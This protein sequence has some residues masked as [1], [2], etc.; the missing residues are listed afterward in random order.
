VTDERPPLLERHT[1]VR[2]LHAWLDEAA[3][4]RGRLVLVS[5]EAGIGKTALLSS[6][7][8]E[9]V[10][11]EVLWG[12][13][14]RLFTPRALGPFVDIAEQVDGALGQLVARGAA[15]HQF[16]A[17]LSDELRARTP[18]VLVIEDVHWA[19]EAT[20]DVI[21]L[22]SRR[23]DQ[24]PALLV[25]SF[26]DDELSVA[27]PLQMV[28]GELAGR[29]RVERI[30]VP[31]LSRDAVR[32][33]AQPFGADDERVFER[34]AGN[35]F[36]VT[37]V[38]AT[39]DARLPA[40]VRDAVLARAAH[41]PGAS[42]RLL[43]CAAAVPSKV[44]IWLLEAIA[45]GDL[46][47]L[48]TCLASGMLRAEG[49]HVAFRHELARLAI[50]E[51]TAP[52]RRV[53]LHRAILKTL[54]AQ[55]EQLRDVARLAHHGEAAGDGEAVLEF[56]PQAARRAA[57]LGSHREAAEQYARALRYAEGLPLEA[58]AD[59]YERRGYECH[60]TDQLA[61][62]LVAAREALDR[63][64]ALGQRIRE[65]DTLVFIS[66]LLWFLGRSEESQQAGSA[67]LAMLGELPDSPEL[68]TAY[69]NMARISLLAHHMG[70]AVEWGTKAIPLAERFEATGILASALN[71]IGV[72]ELA[73]GEVDNGRAKLQRSLE[74]ARAA[75]LEEHVARALVNLGGAMLDIRNYEV[76]ARYIAE[77]LEYTADREL[78]SFRNFLLSIQ[79]HWQLEQGLWDEALDTAELALRQATSR[80]IS[81]IRVPSLRVIGLI[82]ARRGDPRAREALDEALEL[83]VPEELQQIAPVAAACAE[84]A[85]LADDPEAVARITD[86]AFALTRERGD[87]RRGGDL[88]YWR[89][90]AGIEDEP[91]PWITQPYR[92]QIEGDWR[93]AAQDWLRLGCPYEA[94]LA[95][96]EGD[97]EESLRAALAE[98]QRLGAVATARDVTR[99]LRERG[100]RRIGRGPRASTRSNPAGLTARELDVVALLHLQNSEIAARL[101]IS[102]KTVDHHVSAILRKLGVSTRQKAMV[103]AR[104][105]GIQP[106]S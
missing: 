91:G 42:R 60:L 15:P 29:P 54:R 66:R 99:R 37:E 53:A 57:D 106:R 50:D 31:A 21:T 79:A 65:G 11:A 81:L 69:A 80:S 77:G 39:G 67:A 92:R 17:A 90:K 2:A 47:A 71:T 87:P 93:G 88:A 43:E 1:L 35:P 33:L 51:S 84:A 40:T 100:A 102:P 38:L 45:D 49:H 56:A 78:G 63:R 68:A 104:E 55:P 14:E 44:E 48:E 96:A 59:L 74:L 3:D 58:Q 52:D 30:H 61:D 26:R 19:D 89:F 73:Q 23:L 7:C 98:L 82:R 46:S 25:V 105:L 18:A 70:D 8:S 62:A 97:D 10:S 12:G 13:C 9:A 101:Y 20:L 64:K 27:H 76:A 95:L 36:F 103:E 16:V 94:A 28:L 22:L 32:T 83:A 6:F 75:D 4:G 85:W 86:H 34:T 41:L 72:A 24:V 5:G